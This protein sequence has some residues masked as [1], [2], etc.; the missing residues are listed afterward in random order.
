MVPPLV[1]L[2]CLVLASDAL[3]RMCPG[4]SCEVSPEQVDTFQNKNAAYQTE[5]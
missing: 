3:L 2:P 5:E 1:F 4:R